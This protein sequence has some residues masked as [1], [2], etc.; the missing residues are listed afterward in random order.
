MNKKILLIGG[1]GHCK[2]VLD[3]TLKLNKY[4]KIGIIDKMEN[5]GKNI[6]GTPIVGCDEDLPRLIREGYKYAFITI[7]SI[8]N[9]FIRI[10]LFD[11]LIKIGYE[12]PTIIDPSASV[13]EFSEIE[14]GVFIGK[15]SIVNAETVI[16]KAA[17][18][19]SG[20][21]IEHECKIEKFSHIAPGAVL[22][23]SVTI[24]ENSHIGSNSVIKQGI[25]IGENSIIGMGSVV[26]KNINS[27]SMAYGNPCREVKKL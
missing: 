15:N 8:G 22:G 27:N 26:L 4:E 17:I 23:G 7:G 3:S 2:S 24:K 10:K 25:I 20:S 9:P 19:N 5:I 11:L 21:I 6:M 16:E 1:G 18:I 14:K 13:S 12:I